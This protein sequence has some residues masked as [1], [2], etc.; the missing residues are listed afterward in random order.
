MASNNLSWQDAI[1]IVLQDAGEPLHYQEVTN[2]IGQR[3]LRPLTGST[4]A[5]TVNAHLSR[6]TREGES[7]YDARITR[8]GRGIFEFAHLSLDTSIELEEVDEN[9]GEQPDDVREHL[10]PAF[11][12]FWE[13]DKVRWNSNQILGRQ[14]SIADPVNFAEQQGIYLLHNGP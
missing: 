13:R 6:M 2:Q 8:V 14:A 7:I 11:G 4:P 9:A 12:L 3:G 10:V 5:G 1:V